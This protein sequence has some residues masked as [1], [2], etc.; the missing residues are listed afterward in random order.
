L[1]QRWIWAVALAAAAAL[2]APASA[3]PVFAHR[4]GLTCQVCHTEVP[5]LTPFGE[6]FLANGYRIP[7]ARE[8]GV[9]PVAIRVETDYAS[10]G[11]VD[12]DET[13][14][15]LPKTI[16]NEVEV[17]TGGNIGNRVSY[18]GEQYFVDGGFPGNSRDVWMA[19]RLTPDAARIPV[20]VRGGQFTLPLPIDPETFRETVQPYAIYG[21]TAGINPFNFFDVKIGAEV[22]VGNPSR[23]I[24]FVGAVLQGHD[25][26]SGLPAYGLDT[27]FV[28]QRNWGDWTLT[29]YRYDGSRPLAGYGYNSTQFFTGIPDRFW[30]NGYAIGYVHGGT[31]VDGSYQNGN[32][33]SADVYGDALVTSGGFVQVRRTIGKRTFAI[34]RWDTTTGPT[35]AQT[36]TYGVGV[37]PTRN[38]RLTVFQT[39]ERD[40]LGNLQHVIQSSFLIAY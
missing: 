36:W 25:T 39:I 4:F 21:Q 31:E 8:K 28:A 38:T 13:H 19:D 34:A 20:L 29:A 5:H 3:I 24:G 14:G 2:P 7:G 22:E 33:S 10:G 27:M 6:R 11:A 37:G 1:F 40:F 23:Q 9:F 26:Q 17:L 32:D 18:W 35:V 30:R 16:V 12:P 15:P